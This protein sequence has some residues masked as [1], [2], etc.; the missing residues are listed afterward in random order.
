MTQTNGMS[1]RE[2]SLAEFVKAAGK[3]KNLPQPRTTYEM[4]RAQY[5]Q[6]RKVVPASFATTGFERSFCGLEILIKEPDA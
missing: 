3:L 2:F 5:E 1:Q 4:T 6:L